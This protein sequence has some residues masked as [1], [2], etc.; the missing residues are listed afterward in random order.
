MNSKSVDIPMD[1]NVKL[2][3]NQVKSLLDLEKYRSVIGNLNYLTSIT[4]TF[5]W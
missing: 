3:P 1:S 4:L 5:S 2:L